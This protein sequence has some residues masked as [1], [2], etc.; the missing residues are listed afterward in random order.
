M[1]PN[2]LAVVDT[3]TVAL[4]RR[5]L[6]DLVPS[7]HWAKFVHRGANPQIALKFAK[8]ETKLGLPRAFAL[9]KDQPKSFKTVCWLVL[10]CASTAVAAWDMI[11]LL[12]NSVE[13][14]A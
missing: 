1:M 7:I 14:L 10:A 2:R 12:A 4:D 6:N 13:A 3:L 9:V 11:W 8:L 5:A